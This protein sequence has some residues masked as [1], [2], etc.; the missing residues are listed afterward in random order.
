MVLSAL[1]AN[2]IAVRWCD[3]SFNVKRNIIDLQETL[4][5]R[6]KGLP[7]Y[8]YALIEVTLRQ[9]PEILQPWVLKDFHVGYIRI[10]DEEILNSISYSKYLSIIF[11]F[12]RI[13]DISIFFYKKRLF[14]KFIISVFRIKI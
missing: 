10:K 2:F 9:F 4:T 6:N 11:P 7:I 12:D 8:R 3:N 1:V 13:Y 5:R 14:R